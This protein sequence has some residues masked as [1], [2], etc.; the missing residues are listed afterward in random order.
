MQKTSEQSANM[1]GNHFL[2]LTWKII[3]LVSV[4]IVTRSK[5]RFEYCDLSSKFNL[6]SSL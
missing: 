2:S 3:G 4:L 1:T 5:F 6:A